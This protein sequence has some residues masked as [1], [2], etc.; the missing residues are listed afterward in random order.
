M[1]RVVYDC[2]DPSPYVTQDTS[3][4]KEGELA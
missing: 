4:V 2:I 3:N 1:H